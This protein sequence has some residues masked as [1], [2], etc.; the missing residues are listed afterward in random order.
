[1]NNVVK[2]FTIKFVIPNTT[3]RFKFKEFPKFTAS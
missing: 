1:M 3:V 2:S